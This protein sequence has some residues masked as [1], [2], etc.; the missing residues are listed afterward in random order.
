MRAVHARPQPLA[1]SARHA[2]WASAGSMG[3]VAIVA[4]TPNSPFPAILP[5]DY[6]PTG[7]FRWLGDLLFLPHLGHTPLMVLGLLAMVSTGI[8]FLLVLRE[9]WHGRLSMRAV[10]IVAVVFHVVVLTL[11]LLF[12]RD[13]YSYGY[14]GRIV[15]TY[16]ANPY[17]TTPKD[18][19]L[20]SLFRY[21]WP[22]WR[23]TPSVY[24]PLFTWISAA[25]TTVTKSVP[26]LIDGFQVAAAA[27]SLATMAVV[28]RTVKRARPER[29]VFAAAMIGL[30]P[31]VVFHV[32]GGGHNDAF[33][34]LFL[35]LGV[36][37]LY[38]GR[39]TW[40]AVA[41]GLAMSVKA[42]AFVPLVLLIVA[43][44]AKAPPAKRTRTAITVGGLASA[45]W[46]VF[47]LPFLQRTNWSLGLVDV[48]GNDSWMAAG[49]IVVRVFSL[50]GTLLGGAPV[51]GT[52][53]TLARLILFG[54]AATIIVV[55]ARR[56]WLDPAA[57]RPQAL[58]AAWGWGFLALLLLSPVM[59]SWYLMWVLP[60]AW[61]LPRVP[62]RAVVITS[63]VLVAS[64]LVTESAKLPGDLSHVNLAFGHPVTIAVALWVGREFLRSIRDHRGWDEDSPGPAF[65]DRFEDGT[66]KVGPQPRMTPGHSSAPARRSPALPAGL[67]SPEAATTPLA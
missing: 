20:N 15:S 47:A 39:D 16:N 35:A 18:F 4:A 1:R 62:R 14:Y 29:A 25:I 65:G 17:I 67:S 56:I 44:V 5:R 8:A 22:G 42:S 52:M 32:V 26:G 30:N 6:E 3:F 41:L 24:G 7:P 21:T 60:I 51:A 55:L 34:A 36:M 11:P 40:A 37:A 48:A 50:A 64:Q 2:L 49:Q 45:T 33:L 61:A 12:S 53:E 38:A 13:V 59:Y 43:I 28:A 54:T 9:A 63:A 66:P 58:V 57:R 31:V 46:L 19:H 23:G 27:A 10:A